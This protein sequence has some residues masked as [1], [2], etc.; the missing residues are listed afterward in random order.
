MKPKLSKEL[1]AHCAKIDDTACSLFIDTVKGEGWTVRK[2]TK[3][4]DMFQHIDYIISRDGFTLTVDVKGAKRFSDQG[5]FIVEL[6]NVIGNRGWLFGKANIIAF[7]VGNEFLFVDRNKL[8]SIVKEK[9]GLKVYTKGGFS[10]HCSGRQL[11]SKPVM[12]PNFYQRK[13]RKDMITFIERKDLENA[14]TT[15]Q[16]EQTLRENYE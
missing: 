7:Q 4:Q 13:G 9:M 14:R 10:V 12:A 1:L 11:Y 6:V 15:L 16:T 8:Y 5:L 2:S 3:E